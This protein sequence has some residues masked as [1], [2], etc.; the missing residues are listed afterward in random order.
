[1]E[2]ATKQWNVNGDF[3]PKTPFAKFNANHPREFLSLFANLE[4]IRGLLCNNKLGSFRVNF[5]RS[6]GDELYRVG[7]SAVPGA[8]ESRLYFY[9]DSVTRTIYVLNIG[10][11]Q[12][13]SQDITEAKDLMKKIPKAQEEKKQ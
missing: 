5:L 13:Q 1:M 11:K 6:E 2:P 7:Q 4:K 10:T 9:P 12:N 8:T 3:A